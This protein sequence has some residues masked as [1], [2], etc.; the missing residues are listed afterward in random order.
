MKVLSIFESW[1]GL[2]SVASYD[3]EVMGLLFW[4]MDTAS[5]PL[6]ENSDISS[7]VLGRVLRP[8]QDECYI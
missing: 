5:Q 1:K 6:L 7:R 8:P 4:A 2:S 3:S